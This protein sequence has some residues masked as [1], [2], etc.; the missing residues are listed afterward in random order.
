M[1]AI[2]KPVVKNKYWIVEED[3]NK[4]ATIQAVEEGGFSFVQDNTREKFA[5]IK[6]ISKKYNIEFVKAEKI[7]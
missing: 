3:G 7:K 4:V 1:N 2:A 5:S 6:M